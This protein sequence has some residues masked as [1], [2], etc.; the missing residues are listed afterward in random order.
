[1]EFR[2]R[3]CLRKLVTSESRELLH[4]HMHYRRGLLLEAGGIR[5]QPAYYLDAMN[6]IDAQL[7]SE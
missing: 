3:H 7:A 2:T 4:L 6:V 5:N 1:M